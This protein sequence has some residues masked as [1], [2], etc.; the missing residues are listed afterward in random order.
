MTGLL[1]SA[2]IIL[3]YVRKLPAGQF[4]KELMRKYLSIS[5]VFFI[6]GLCN[7]LINNLGRLFLERYESVKEIGL[8]TAGN[9]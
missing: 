5:L 4:D 3:Y 9:A 2:P 6:I 8:F 7:T 1:V